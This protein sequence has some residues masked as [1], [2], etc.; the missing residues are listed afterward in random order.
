MLLCQRRPGYGA[1]A[2][3]CLWTTFSFWDCPRFGH[4]VSIFFFGWLSSI[5]LF[6]VILEWHYK[7][8]RLISVHLC[9]LSKMSDKKLSFNFCSTEIDTLFISF[10]DYIQS[11]F[12]LHIFDYIKS[13]F[14]PH[15]I[16][17]NLSLLLRLDK[18]LPVFAY[19][20]KNQVLVSLIFSILVLWSLFHLFLLWSLLFPSFC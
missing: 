16:Y 15:F 17:L 19:F 4:W 5:F 9:S 20:F 13:S 3:L 8:R 18:G 7:A 12:M 14:M 11:S 6:L 1:C 2:E 10:F